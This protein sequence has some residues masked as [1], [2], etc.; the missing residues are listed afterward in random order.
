VEIL[1]PSAVQLRVLFMKYLFATNYVL[2]VVA[3]KLWSHVASPTELILG[4]AI[5]NKLDEQPGWKCWVYSADEYRQTVVEPEVVDPAL[6]ALVPQLPINEVGNVDFGIFKP[7]LS[8]R[9]PIVVVECDGHEFHQLTHEQASNDR[10]RD[11]RLQYWRIPVLRFTGTDV[12]R[13]SEQ[14]AQ[15]VVDFV[16]ERVNRISAAQ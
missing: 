7:S 9:W 15:E 5:F 12:V 1:K 3:C 16:A 14:F 10:R 6:I 13:G 11:R 8:K 2:N 4:Q